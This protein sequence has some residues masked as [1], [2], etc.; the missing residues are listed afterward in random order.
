MRMQFMRRAP[1]FG[2]LIVA[3]LSGAMLMSVAL[4]AFAQIGEPAHGHAQRQYLAYGGHNFDREPSAISNT[5]RTLALSLMP[6]SEKEGKR[7][8]PYSPRADLLWAVTPSS[9]KNTYGTDSG[10]YGAFTRDT[11]YSPEHC[12]E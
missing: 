9:A 4:N 5:R 6:L 8:Q 7:R 12:G 2:N 11:C 3:V 10:R 1:F